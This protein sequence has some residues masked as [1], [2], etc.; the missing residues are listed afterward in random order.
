M[1]PAECVLNMVIMDT[2]KRH[3]LWTNRL[4]RWWKSYS[5]YFSKSYLEGAWMKCFADPMCF[6]WHVNVTA[7]P[8][9]LLPSAMQCLFP[10]SCAGCIHAPVMKEAAPWVMIPGRIWNSVEA[11]GKPSI[12]TELPFLTMS[13]PCGHANLNS[14]LHPTAAILLSAITIIKF[15]S[16]LLSLCM[17]T[18]KNIC[19]H[20]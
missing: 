19:I 13:V 4:V 5:A 3:V 7:T 14:F 11:H 17:H 16:Y 20:M 1:D 18:N 6:F 10:H 8:C 9:H 15:N 12:P 2:H